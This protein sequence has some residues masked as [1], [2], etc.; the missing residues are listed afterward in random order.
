MQFPLII[1]QPITRR[2]PP[3]S[4][5]QKMEG[6]VLQLARFCWSCLPF[7]ALPFSPGGSASPRFL[8]LSSYTSPSFTFFLSLL[9]SSIPLAVPSPSPPAAAAS[10]F[11]LSVRDPFFRLPSTP[12]T[13]L[14]PVLLVLGLFPRETHLVDLHV[15]S[16]FFL[17]LF[18]TPQRLFG[19]DKIY[20]ICEEADEE[21]L[22]RPTVPLRDPFLPGRSQKPPTTKHRFLLLRAPLPI[23]STP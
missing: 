5:K 1:Y 13:L 20:F 16:A 17:L 2:R 10:L 19:R 7:P 18:R 6:T 14:F 11:Q 8:F 21:T 12:A 23:G 22:F 3:V 15:P 9:T 4:A